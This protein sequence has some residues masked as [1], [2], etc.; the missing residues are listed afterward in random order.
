L[1]MPRRKMLYPFWGRGRRPGKKK[2]GKVP[3]VAPKGG[4]PAAPLV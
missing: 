2:K 3:L 1:P 4:K